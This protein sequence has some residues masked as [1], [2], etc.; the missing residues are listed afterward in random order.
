MV[1]VNP[2]DERLELLPPANVARAPGSLDPLRAEGGG[3]FIACLGLAAD[4]DDVGT[5]GCECAH[6][7]EAQP[8]RT[9]GHDGDAPRQVKEVTGVADAGRRVLG[10]SCF[11]QSAVLLDS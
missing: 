9:A 4:D 5:C 7:G 3:N 1:T 2:V 10:V 6:H 11:R 8:A